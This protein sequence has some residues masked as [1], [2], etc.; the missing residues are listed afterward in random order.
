MTQ[1]VFEPQD[2]LADWAEK[3]LPECAPVNR[4]MTR[5]FGVAS[6]KGELLAVAFFNNY[7]HNDRDIE[8]SMVAATPRWATPGNI[9]AL[10]HYPFVQLG[11]QRLTARTAKSNK[12][13]RSIVERCGA[14]LEGVHPYGYL[15]KRTGLT[16]GLYRDVANERWFDGQLT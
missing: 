8:F 16:Y 4:P 2:A 10:L 3:M 5:F 6:A 12:R 15:G 7:R 11:V 13:V 1:L 9:R 14:K